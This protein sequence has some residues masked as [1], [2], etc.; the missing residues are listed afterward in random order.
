MA[1]W[2]AGVRRTLSPPYSTNVDQSSR[3]WSPCGRLEQVAAQR[4][5]RPAAG[6]IACA[7][8]SNR[9][10]SR[11]AHGPGPRIR[12]KKLGSLSRAAA[13]RPDGRHHLGRAVGIMLVEPGAEQRRDLVRQADR[14]DRSRPRAPASAAA[15][16]IASSSWSVICGTTGAI[17]TWQG[18]PASFERLDRREP[19]ARRRRARLERPC[20]LRVERGHRNRDR[21]DAR[22]RPPARAGRGRAARGRTWW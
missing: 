19:L 18:T 10:R 20:D 2:L 1:T 21:R 9:V 16:T 4:E 13:Q 17:A 8:I 14:Q 5:L 11:S 3:I 15:S 7:A 22:A 6:R 12:L